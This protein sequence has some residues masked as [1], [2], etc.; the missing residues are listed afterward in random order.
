[1]VDSKYII[2]IIIA[3]VVIA[4]AYM[5]FASG[6]NSS[7]ITIAGSTSVQPVAE[8]LAQAYMQK[9]PNVKI[10][11]QGGGSGVGIK[12]VSEGTVNIGTSSKDLSANES[13]GLKQTVIGKD[14]IVIA[15]NTANS[16]NGLTIAQLKDIFSG[17]VTNWNQVG[18][19]NGN[20]DV[21]TRED[22]SGTR[23]AFEDLVLN[24]TAKI[25]ADAIVQSSTEA[26]KQSVKGDP[27]AIGF[28]SLADLDTT[29]KALTV[30]G[31]TP[32]EQTVS[33][34]TYK[35]QRPFIFLTKGEPKGAVKD[36]I[37]WVMGPEGQAIVK[38]ANVVPA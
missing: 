31:V 20:I 2:G 9:N 27:N 19:S 6:S 1:M 13:T 32:S 14:G 15:V 24:K 8:K 7:K 12:S 33:D 18:G 23:T 10:N 38:S 29:V 16:V 4:G 3:L 30:N 22:G 21:I 17:N 36:F 5:V 25:K 35:L 37:D 11:V 26:V 34:G 28:I